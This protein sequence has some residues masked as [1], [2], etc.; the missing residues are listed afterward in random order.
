MKNDNLPQLQLIRALLLFFIVTLLFSGLTAI[1]VES[2]LSFL[3]RFFKMGS[4]M[5]EWLF[6]ILVAYRDVQAKYPFLLYGYDWL[7]FAHIVLAI[8]F[9]GPY[10]NPVRNIWVIEFGM[11]ACIL[12]LPM[13]FIAGPHRG[14]PIAWMLIRL[15]I[16]NYWSDTVVCLLHPDKTDHQGKS[17]LKTQ[18]IWKQS[19]KTFFQE[20]NY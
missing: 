20:V 6:Q 9:I 15:L 11:I 18:R 10:R 17:F 12:I 4:F 1:P 16:W 7:A 3:I 19:R 5:H 13:A 14:I 2:E 8:L